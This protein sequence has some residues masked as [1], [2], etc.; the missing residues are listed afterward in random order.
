MSSR[1]RRL[2]VFEQWWHSITGWRMFTL[3]AT[4]RVDCPKATARVGG[5]TVV[6]DWRHMSAQS[7]GRYDVHRLGSDGVGSG[8]PMQNGVVQTRSLTWGGGYGSHEQHT[9]RIPLPAA[10][11]YWVTGYPVPWFDRRCIVRGVDG[12]V[13]ELIQFDQDLGR[14]P[15]GL[16]QQALSFGR[17]RD[18]VL[19]EGKAVTATQLPSHMFVWGPG[20]AEYPHQQALVVD[21]YVGADGDLTYGPRAGG[22][23]AL[24]PESLSFVRMHGLG[25]ECRARALALV[26]HGCRLIDRN[27]IG[28]TVPNPPSLTTQAGT[29]TAGTNAHLF[30]VRLTDLRRVV[31]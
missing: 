19:V 31:G 21:N 25:G 22:W 10:G 1:V 9:T 18:G 14:L 13:C 12:D 27:G 11:R 26:T 15:A 2:T 4:E 20:S 24:D 5:L 3:P 23:Y 17:W 6:E 8:T 30:Q 28:Q 16:P 29:W 7:V